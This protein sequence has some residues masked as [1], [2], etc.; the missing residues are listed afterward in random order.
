[1]G[2]VGPQKVIRPAFC[3]FLVALGL[4]FILLFVQGIEKANK[5]FVVKQ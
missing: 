2:R 4:F 5:P 1:M 3:F